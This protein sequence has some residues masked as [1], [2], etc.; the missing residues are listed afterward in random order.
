M[1][2]PKEGV[3]SKRGGCEKEPQAWL[4]IRAHTRE[5]RHQKSQG[6]PILTVKIS[7]RATGRNAQAARYAVMRVLERCSWG[8]IGPDLHMWS[9]LLPHGQGS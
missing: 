1:R 8:D 6:D 9:D 2:D 3:Y 4:R 7:M 5:I